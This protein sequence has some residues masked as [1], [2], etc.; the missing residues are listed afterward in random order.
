MGT[1]REKR[2]SEKKLVSLHETFMNLNCC[3][4]YGNNLHE[5]AQELVDTLKKGLDEVLEL[6]EKE[7]PP[8]GKK[9]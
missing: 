8:K 9:F 4:W 5:D 2:E 1:S 6:M 7:R 3:V